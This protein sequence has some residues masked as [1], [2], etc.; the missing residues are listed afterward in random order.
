VQPAEDLRGRA[1][2]LVKLGF[3]RRSLGRFEEAIKT[4]R[5]AL[6]ALADLGDAAE[7][8]RVCVDASQQLGWAARWVEATEMVQRGL[9][10]LGQQETP[11]R[12]R[13]LSFGGALI[14]WV[15]A[16]RPGDEMTDEA[17]ELARRIG[18]E[19]LLG[20]ALQGKSLHHYAFME[21]ER[22]AETGLEA[23]DLLRRS[24]NLWDL[25]TGLP[26]VEFAHSV[27]GRWDE[28]A[29]IDEEVAP[30]AQRLGNYG[31]ILL[32]NRARRWS[33]YEPFDLDTYERFGT[34]DL[35]MNQATG[36]PWGAQALGWL[37]VVEFWR[38]RWDRALELFR[39]GAD[40]EPFGALK[41]FMWGLF[42]RHHAYLGDR[43]TFF[44]ELKARSG[45]YPRLG[46]PNTWGSWSMPAFAAEGFF[47]LGERERA[48]ETYPFLA[49]PVEHGA[50]IRSIDLRL[51]QTLL[52]IAAA[53]GERW[54]VADEHY[55]RALEQADQYRLEVECADVRRF[56]GQMLLER[57]GLG[58]RGR[59][60][61]AEA[62][63]RYRRIGMP[64]HIEMAETLLAGA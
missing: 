8:G 28:L 19:G 25:A 50:M 59:E 45:E 58:E 20:L 33:G 32:S 49:A 15:G 23:A 47:L 44:A 57:G 22:V 21:L 37:G 4:W 2:L 52:G 9:L 13:L 46:E 6:D 43:E 26:F 38:G 29:R 56:Y 12:A 24:G 51:S 61:L 41:N 10:A 55:R 1:D 34:E 17:L 3:A 54:D 39:R 60:L 5:E 62:S 35:E 16:Y 64:R 11:E 63:D 27:M 40:E 42:L 7:V 53:A 48:A 30:L 31:A 14:S 18:D 36:L